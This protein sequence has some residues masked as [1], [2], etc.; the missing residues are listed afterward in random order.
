MRQLLGGIL[1]LLCAGL[2]QAQHYSYSMGGTGTADTLIGNVNDTTNVFSL[3]V[4]DNTPRP[5]DPCFE[6]YFTELTDMSTLDSVQAQLWVTDRPN[7]A[8]S[9]NGWMYVT[10][11]NLYT[12]G[13]SDADGATDA[14]ED[15]LIVADTLEYIPCRY[16]R[17]VLTCVGGAAGDSAAYIIYFVGDKSKRND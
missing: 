3:Y 13:N 1:L 15:M 5:G 11:Y 12:F 9:G 4:S 10:T 7:L 14:D 16:A 2:V 6:V 8:R 17:I